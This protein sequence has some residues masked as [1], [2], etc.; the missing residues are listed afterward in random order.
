M[1]TAERIMKKK[2]AMRAEVGKFLPNK[3]TQ[4]IP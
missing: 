3:N 1:K 2:A 4:N